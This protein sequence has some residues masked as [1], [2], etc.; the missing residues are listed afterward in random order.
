MVMADHKNAADIRNGR[1]SRGASPNEFSDDSSG[2]DS[3]HDNGMRVGDDFQAKVPVYNPDIKPEG[4]NDAI[5]VWAPAWDL[6]D[7]KVDEYVV[8]AKEKHGYNTE[9]ALGM[10]F[11]H[12]HNIDKALSDLAN[13]TPFP[14]EW[15][16]EDKVLFEQ[17][18]SFHGKSFHR[19]RQMLPDKSIASLVKYYYSWKKTRSRTSLMDR[20][21][22]KL[23]KNGDS[24][25]DSDIESKKS[26][27]DDANKENGKQ[28]KDTCSNCGIST[29]TLNP[30]PKGSL[31]NSCFQYWR[32]TG[33]MRS[34]GPNRH[35]HGQHRHNPMKHKRKPPRGMFI[36]AEDLSLFTS[37]PPAQADAVL[38][39]AEADLVSLK[40]QVQNHKQMIS[41]QKHKMGCID[42]LRPPEG[43]QRINA[44]WTNEELLLAVQ[45]VRKYG[46]DFQAIAEVIGNKTEAHVRSFFINFRRRYNLDEVLAEFEA[47]HG[48]E[49]TNDDDLDKEEEKMEVDIKEPDNSTPSSG[50]PP[51]LLKQG[52][53]PIKVPSVSQHRLIPNQRT[54][55]QQPPPLI[56]PNSSSPKPA[57]TTPS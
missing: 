51:P 36:I 56:K 57:I 9:Q 38:K 1:R 24:E 52:T 35:D 49:H 28:E 48:T 2:E 40:R 20:Q 11:W 50:T 21:A 41:M 6:P 15:T 26:D 5:L 31:C 13:F 8:I 42:E 7:A 54:I 39:N 37:G 45:G 27:A 23:T 16:V 34:A 32:R 22:R 30:T 33:V 19:I 17:A 46:K 47:E 12:K 29:S 10:L 55:L 4:R 18:F 44:R 14:D 3:D 43:N 25:E 53:S